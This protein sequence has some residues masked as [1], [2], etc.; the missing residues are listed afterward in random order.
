MRRMANHINRL[1]ARNEDEEKEFYLVKNYFLTVQTILRT[2]SQYPFKPASI[3]IYRELEKVFHSLDLVLQV[4]DSDYLKQFH[5]FLKQIQAYES[6]I[7][8]FETIFSFI[9]KIGSIGNKS[10]STELT[11]QK[12]LYDYIH[13]LSSSDFFVT[14]WIQHAQKILPRWLFNLFRYISYP[15]FQKTN[16]DLEHYNLKIKR[17]YRK[18]TGRKKC[19]LFLLSSGSPIAFLL[20][21]DFDFTPHSF[22]SFSHSSILK[23]RNSLFQTQK[24]SFIHS[25][26]RSL[27]DVLFFLENYSFS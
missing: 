12:A 14:Q 19:H 1:Q 24:K 13:S 27:D 4:F 7:I 15:F 26:K 23:N 20:S 5:S 6:E 3:K 11:A 25:V 16:N 18:I 22:A 2:K 21:S 9:N 8:S 10:H 17:V